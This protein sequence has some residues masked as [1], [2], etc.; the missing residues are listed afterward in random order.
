MLKNSTPREIAIRTSLFIGLATEGALLLIM[1]LP[2]VAFS[3]WI[4]LLIGPATSLIS[5]FIVLTTLDHYIYRKIKLIYKTIHSQKVS[6]DIK[7]EGI[8][9]DQPIIDDVEQEVAEWAE[10]QQEQLNQYERFAEYRR[11]YVGDISHELKTPIFNIQGYLHTLMDHGYGDEKIT[12]SFIKKAAKNVERLQTIVEDLSAISR[13]ESGDLMFDPEP[14][15]IKELAQEVIEELDLKARQASITLGFKPGAD[16]GVMVSADRES[17]RQ[18][19]IN[20]VTNSIKY[21][22]SGGATRFGFYD[23][24]SYI[25]CEVADNGIGIP[26]KHLPHVFDRFYRV[27]KSRSRQKGGSGLGLSIVKHIMEAHQ[28]TI[29][30]RSTQGLGS[31]FGITLAKA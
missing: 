2:P 25:L 5:Y 30:V 24:E 31:T 11:R 19:L 20:L 26:E 28:Q 21:G 1:A 10:S 27:D 15:N 3:W 9:P 29:N 16:S 8:D 7:R 17:I 22:N 23:M 4:V 6:S 13:L 14:F 18:V 12:K